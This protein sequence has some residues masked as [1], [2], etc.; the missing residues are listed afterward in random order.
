M[1]IRFH[2]AAKMMKVKHNWIG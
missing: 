1:T 2:F